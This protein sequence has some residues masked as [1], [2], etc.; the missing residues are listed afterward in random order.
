MFCDIFLLT[1][2]IY[3]RCGRY[4][5][6]RFVFGCLPVCLHVCLSPPSFLCFCQHCVAH[7]S[8]CLPAVSL[9]SVSRSVCL[10]C[11]VSQSVIFL[12]VTL[13]PS[14]PLCQSVCAAVSLSLSHTHSA[15]LCL[16][17]LPLFLYHSV[18]VCPSVGLSLSPP[19]PPSRPS[20]VPASFSV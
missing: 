11:S 18:S 5:L 4:F 10:P 20:L 19:R 8:A 12:I 3:I 15:C 16:S 13:C 14:L 9:S 2:A 7:L 17:L 1:E 6:L